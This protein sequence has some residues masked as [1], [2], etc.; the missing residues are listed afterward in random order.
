MKFFKFCQFFADG[1]GT[2]NWIIYEKCNN[3]FNQILL[4]Y[5]KISV[6]FIRNMQILHLKMIEN[7]N[8]PIF[9]RSVE[10]FVEFESFE[11]YFIYFIIKRMYYYSLEYF[12][13][14]F[15]CFC[16]LFLLFNSISLKIT[17]LFSTDFVYCS[18]S[19][20]EKLFLSFAS[21]IFFHWMQLKLRMFDAYSDACR[22]TFVIFILSKIFAS[23][24]SGE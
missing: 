2:F 7:K 8:L 9:L 4:K 10:F 15:S 17:L 3:I 14:Y 23:S 1:L 21:H 22:Y 20:P 24:I 5:L 19:I 13:T 16:F 11:S 18:K 12:T 6:Q